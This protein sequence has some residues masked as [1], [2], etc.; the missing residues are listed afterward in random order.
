M[1]EI[2]TWGMYALWCDEDMYYIEEDRLELIP[3]RELAKAATFDEAIRII[4]MLTTGALIIRRSLA[5]ACAA[6]SD[7]SAFDSG[8]LAR[9]TKP[10]FDCLMRTKD[11]DN[12]A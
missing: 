2:G 6:A 1:I 3:G 9:P 8:I 12:N 4:D 10:K 7:A 11:S 5:S